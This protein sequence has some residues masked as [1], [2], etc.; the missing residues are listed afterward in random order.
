MY[1]S[2]Q[3]LVKDTQLEVAR[4]ETRITMSYKELREKQREA[5]TAF[6]QGID[7]YHCTVANRLW[8]VDN[9]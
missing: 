2:G 9:I 8:E 6:V 3:I 5:I 1:M 7:W 4:E